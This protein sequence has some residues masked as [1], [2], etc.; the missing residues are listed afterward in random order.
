MFS[1]RFPLVF[2]RVTIDLRRILIDFLRVPTDFQRTPIDFHKRSKFKLISWK[3]LLRSKI[4]YSIQRPFHKGT[5]GLGINCHTGRGYSWTAYAHL[6]LDLRM[7]SS[8]HL[9]FP[10]VSCW[11]HAVPIDFSKFPTDFQSRWVADI[12][13]SPMMRSSAS[14]TLERVRLVHEVVGV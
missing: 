9:W 4:C 2:M 1:S 13:D 6:L 7:H 3:L 5:P 12:L 10:E 8:L 14:G 11:D